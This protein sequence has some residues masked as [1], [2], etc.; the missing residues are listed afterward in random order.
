MKIKKI[1]QTDKLA[2][3][4]D[5]EI[6]ITHNYYVKCGDVNLVSHNSSVVSNSTNG[7]EP[8]KKFMIYKS[9][10]SGKLPFIVPS[11]HAWKNK[12]TLQFEMKNNRGY[13]NITGAIQKWMDMAISCMHYYNY[14]HY[15]DNKLPDSRLVNE[16]IYHYSIGNKTLYYTY[17]NDLDKQ[18]VN[19]VEVEGVSEALIET[20]SGC[21]SGAC[22]L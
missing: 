4:Y 15:E 8:I 12:Y 6:D 11:Y 20:E 14:E 13:S 21:E 2:P 1:T 22:S 7:I 19:E 5:I 10:K 9:S 16:F 18:S 17:S 3:T